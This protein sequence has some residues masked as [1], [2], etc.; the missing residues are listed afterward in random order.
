MIHIEGVGMDD[1]KQNAQSL[2][3][4]D[5][6]KSCENEAKDYQEGNS[7]ICEKPDV[8]KLMRVDARNMD[9][10]AS[11]PSW[12]KSTLPKIS[13][14]MNHGLEVLAPSIHD[15]CPAEELLEMKT[16]TV[17]CMVRNIDEGKCACT[18]YYV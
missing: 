5:T 18:I 8:A 12:L 17:R 1:I 10:S 2:S 16:E 9:N 4:E 6:T 15:L 7:T 14:H 11:L 3:D 13:H